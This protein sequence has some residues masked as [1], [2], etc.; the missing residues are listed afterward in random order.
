MTAPGP[1]ATVVVCEHDRATLDLLCDRL[2]SDGL[3]PLAARTAEEAW[4][5]CRRHRPD[6]L[7][8]DLEL[9]DDSG[10]ELLRRVRGAHWLQTQ[11][12]PGLGPAGDRIDLRCAGPLGEP[13]P[14]P[15][16]RRP[17]RE[18]LR[19][20][21]PP[22]PDR[23]CPPP[24]S[25]PTR[26]AGAGRGAARGPGPS[27]GGGRRPGG[28]SR[29]EGVHAPPRPRLRSDPGLRQGG[30]AARRLGAAGT[31]P[32]DPHPRQ[33][34]QPPAPQTRS[35]APPLRRELLG[36]GYRLVDSVEEVGTDA[37]GGTNAG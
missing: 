34:R 25:Q 7:V 35:R 24:T 26:R 23:G 13:G 33:S 32:E 30:V 4:R 37:H 36:V 1:I 14:R 27:Q 11:V 18:A 29:Q 6:L 2:A 12:D 9:P 20:R 3:E 19:L 5:L 22:R 28:A 8:V 17:P 16:R 10:P 21:R 15:G 31:G